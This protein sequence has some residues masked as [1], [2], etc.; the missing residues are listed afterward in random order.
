MEKFQT[1]EKLNKKIIFDIL[2][3]LYLLLFGKII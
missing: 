3:E 1:L 2:R